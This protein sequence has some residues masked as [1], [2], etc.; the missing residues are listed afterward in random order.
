MA[1]QIYELAE[2]SRVFNHSNEGLG[3]VS[4]V[5]NEAFVREFARLIIEECANFADEY[6]HTMYG[7]AWCNG[8]AIRDHFGVE[9]G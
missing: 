7:R 5:T 4:Y 9:N 3:G 1:D 2:R 6:N 8:D